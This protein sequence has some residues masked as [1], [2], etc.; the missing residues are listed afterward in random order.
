M[1]TLEKLRFTVEAMKQI[2]EAQ[3]D[4]VFMDI[5]LNKADEEISFDIMVSQSHFAMDLCR[6]L[7]IRYYPTAAGE[8]INHLILP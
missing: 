8:K 3:C 7:N 2:N 1:K 6:L 4:E 5:E